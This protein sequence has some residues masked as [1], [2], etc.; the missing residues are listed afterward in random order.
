LISLLFLTNNDDYGRRLCVDEIM[1]VYEHFKHDLL[2]KVAETMPNASMEELAAISQ[3]MD[4]VSTNYSVQKAET[5]IAVVGR[6]EF[7][8]LLKTFI[9]VK[10]MEGLSDETLQTYWLR[11]SQFM[12][13]SCKPVNEITANDIR[14]YLFAYQQN[15]GVTNRSL[16]HIRI[17]IATFFRWAASEKYIPS[18]PTENLKAI[19]YTAKE[20][21]P[22]NQIEL[23]MIRRACQTP[24]ELAIIEFLYSTG[25]RVTELTRIKM[26][27]V[28]WNKRSVTLFGKGNK[29]RTSYI[30]AKAEVA[31]KHYL[32]K[33]SH[34]SD[35][36][37]CNDRGG[38]PMNK[39]NIERI[40]RNIKNRA[41]FTDRNIT[42]HTFRHT[43]ATQALRSGMPVSDIQ[44]LLGHANVSTTMIYAHTCNEKV[45]AEHS[46]CVI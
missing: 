40:V 46:R 22:L 23:E 19:K 6:E 32:L 25:C 1:N 29:Y 13:A 2:L 45:Q 17:V 20:R 27:D 39:D 26:S 18:N 5:A 14:T 24:R 30:N 15:R 41:G 34:K 42:P 11:L 35:L 16:D 21:E 38:T 36:L 37:F 28:D 9:V 33:R 43:T 31:L 44:M 8:K 4:S 10:H 7:Q 3:A 12:Y